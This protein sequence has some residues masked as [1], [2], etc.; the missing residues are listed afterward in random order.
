MVC[1]CQFELLP[2]KSCMHLV[3]PLVMY[4]DTQTVPDKWM[5]IQRG[6]IYVV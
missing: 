5:P 3:K 4:L 6:P 2:D 1:G